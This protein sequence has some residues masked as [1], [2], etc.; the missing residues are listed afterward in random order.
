VSY[1]IKVRSFVPWVV[2]SEALASFRRRLKLHLFHA[3]F[4]AFPMLA[5]SASPPSRR[6]RVLVSIVHVTSTQEHGD[7]AAA[8]VKIDRLATT[9]DGLLC[10]F[11]HCDVKVLVVTMA[12]RHVVDFLP[13]RLRA[14]CE[15]VLVQGGDPMFIGFPAQDE[16]V[17][18]RDAHDWFIF[19]EDDIEIRDA[20]FLDKVARFCGRPD[21]Q[22]GVLLPN[23]FEYVDGVKRYIDLTHRPEFVLWNKFSTVRQDDNVLAE[24]SIHH[25]GVFCLSRAQLDMLIA[26]GR[27]WRGLDIYSGSRESA[28]TYSLMECFTLYK[29]HEDNLHYLEVRHVD[30]R[31]SVMHAK[32]KEFTYSAASPVTA[33]AGG[34]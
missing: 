7:R 2:V 32:V 12:Q 27:D 24:C 11:A 1:G 22:R 18:R 26:T 20:S 9:L 10:S 3:R 25:A 21:M 17:A 8:A 33:D 16:L 30:S 34:R 23:R 4:A 15:L 28:A 19:I 14:V 6:P 29:P 31:Y 5:A 13:T